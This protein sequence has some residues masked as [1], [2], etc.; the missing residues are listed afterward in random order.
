MI[1]RECARRFR[2][3]ILGQDSASL[4]RGSVDIGSRVMEVTCRRRDGD[5]CGPVVVVARNRTPCDPVGLDFRAKSPT[6]RSLYESVSQNL[7]CY[8]RRKQSQHVRDE[9]TEGFLRCDTK[10]RESLLHF[11]TR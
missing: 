4:A 5:G 10:K 2:S 7:Q 3:K 1:A 8:A 11:G 9:S 6:L